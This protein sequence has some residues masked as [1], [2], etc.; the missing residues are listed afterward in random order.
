MKNFEFKNPTKILF[1]KNQI[2]KLKDELP[3]DAKILLLYGGGSIKKNGIYEQVKNALSSHTVMEFGGIPPNPEYKVLLDALDVIKKNEITFLLAV[4]GGSVIDGTKFLSGAAYYEGQEPWE[5]LTNKK[6]ITEGLP[7]GTV[8]TLP[9]T[10]SEMNSGSVITREETQEKLGM[11]GPGLFPVFSILDPQ[12]VQSIPERQIAN[13]LADAFTHVLEQYVT[14]PVDAQ[15]Q[16][17]FA[18]SILQTLIAIAPKILKDPSDYTAAA[19][20]MWSC[21][22]ALNGLIQKGVP[23]DW[24]VHAMGH[25]LT[26]LYGIDHARTLAIISSSHYTYNF[27]SKKE[28]LAQYATRVWNV[29]EGSIDEKAKIA[30]QKTEEFFHSLGIKTKLSAYTEDYKNTAKTIA[31]RFTDRGWT[32]IGEH[33]KLAPSDVEKIVEM[34]Y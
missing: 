21:T 10:G 1:G 11:G 7:F 9:A 3:K 4:G 25:E 13:G 15:L 6:P 23:T 28:K 19:N 27:E 32:G 8:L 16:D 2:S 18:E 31:N 24:A 34:S 20:F 22:M 29:T 12:V 5:L 14:Y 26:A 33:G 17:R 30:I